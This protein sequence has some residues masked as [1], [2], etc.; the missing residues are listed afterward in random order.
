MTLLDHGVRELRETAV[1]VDEDAIVARKVVGED[2]L[3]W[4]INPGKS[5][6]NFSHCKEASLRMWK[7]SAPAIVMPTKLEL[8]RPL[9]VFGIGCHT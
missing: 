7:G 4:Q 6:E 8:I 1:S 2:D 3:V 5:S 9:Y